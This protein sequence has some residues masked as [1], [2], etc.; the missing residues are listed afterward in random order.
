MTL[1]FALLDGDNVAITGDTKIVMDLIQEKIEAGLTS[2]TASS[3]PLFGS[4]KF[5]KEEITTITLAAIQ[6]AFMITER[7]LK[8]RRIP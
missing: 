1:K 6:D 3:K 7:I 8:V 4:K 5:T 2:S